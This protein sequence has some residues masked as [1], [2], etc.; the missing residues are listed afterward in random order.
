MLK[1]IR[2][3]LKNAFAW[4]L[5]IVVLIPFA[6]MLVNSLKTREESYSMTLKLPAVLQFQ[7]YLTVIEQGNVIPSFF[8]SFMYASLSVVLVV[9]TCSMAAFVISRNDTRLNRFAYFFIIMGIVLPVNYVALMKVMQVTMLNNTR[10]GISLL[11]TAMNIPIS[12]FITCS[13]IGSIPKDLDE[14]AIIDGCGPWSLFFRIIFPLL[15][16]VAVTVG[17]LCFMASWNDFM[18]PLYYLNNSAKWPMSLT[19]YSFF[20]ASMQAQRQWNLVCADIVLT[21][22]PVIVVY[23]LGQKYIVSGITAGAVKG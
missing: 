15:K 5:S 4:L 14:A 12:L 16:P 2:P 17:V 11:Y 8:N 18:M 21:S 23:L 9:L 6:V 10:L 22:I 7:N 20:G 13:F 3:L 19:V 1:W